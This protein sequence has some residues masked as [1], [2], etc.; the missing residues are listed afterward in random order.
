MTTFSASNARGKILL[1][2]T[3]GVLILLLLS[4]RGDISG[5]RVWRSAQDKLT[6][7]T[8]SSGGNSKGKVPAQDAL[9]ATTTSGSKN[10]KPTNSKK[11][12]KPSK[13]TKQKPAD[14][15]DETLDPC[16]GFPDTSDILVVMKTGATEAYEKLPIHFMSTLKCANDSLLVS[17][18]EMDMAGHHLV[19]VLAD[20]PPALQKDNDDF[21]LYRQLQEFKKL[22]QDPRTLKGDH[23]GWNLD[24][25]KFIP[26]LQRTWKY[27]PDASWYVF[28]EADTGVNWDN[29]RTYLDTLDPKKKYY[30]GSPTY[31]DIEF[32]HGGTGYVISNAAMK[33]AVGDHLEEIGEKYNKEVQDICCGDRMIA[34]VLL[35]QGINLTRAWPMFNGEKPITVPFKDNS[36]CQPFITMHHMTAQEVS[37]VWN[38]Q[39]QRKAKGLKVHPPLNS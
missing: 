12:K 19:D 3:F 25:Y 35:D 20:F 13:P 33:V 7:G 27:N 5:T 11:P 17:D 23:N 24:K 18:M 39:Q 34:R 22:R 15:E 30:I 26:M 1:G 29:L 21:K 16:Y 28:V 2:V 38:Y 10:A 9:K 14:S 4:F 32:A 8:S 6:T 36:W 31:L 37:Q